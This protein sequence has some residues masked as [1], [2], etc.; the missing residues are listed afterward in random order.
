MAI[1]DA[2][3][4]EVRGASATAVADQVGLS[5]STTARL[6]RQL[7][8]EGLLLR[9]RET[10]RLVLG[11]RLLALAA[12]TIRP[13]SLIDAALPVMTELRNRTGETVSLHVRQ[14]HVRVCVA[15]V[16]SQRQVRRVVPVGY[17]AP[18]YKSATSEVLLAALPELQR[19]K[20][21]SSAPLTA[22]ERAAMAVRL[23]QIERDGWTTSVD[24][25]EVGLAGIAA[26][27]RNGGR[28]IAAL[29]VSGPSSRWTASVMH[30]FAPDIVAAAQEIGR[31][32]ASLQEFATGQPT[33]DEAIPLGGDPD[34]AHA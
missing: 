33:A 24:L 14:E 3:S 19:E 15:E 18:L 5:L 30:G 9:S 12:A 29:S 6:I 27:V 1:L 17:T 28:T 16:Q 4:R 23:R 20:R 13:V 34:I 11:P 2:V 8:Q 25:V 26:S 7:E 10:G 21:L 22:L 32:I 31:R